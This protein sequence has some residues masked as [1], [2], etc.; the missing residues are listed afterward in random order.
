MAISTSSRRRE[1][2]AAQPVVEDM[3]DRGTGL[4]RQLRHP[5]QVSGRQQRL[6]LLPQAVVAGARDTQV[7][8]ALDGDGNTQR[9]YHDDRVHEYPAG[10]EESDDGVVNVHGI[11]PVLPR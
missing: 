2:R 3:A 11:A 5:G 9:E 1:V 10:L 8:P 7:Q 4:F 6:D